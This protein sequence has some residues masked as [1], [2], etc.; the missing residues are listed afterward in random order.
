LADVAGQT[1]FQS[2]VVSSNGR[3]MPGAGALPVVEG[4]SVVGAIAVAGGTEEQDQR[5]AEV[6]LASYRLGVNIGSDRLAAW[7]KG[8]LH[9]RDAWDR[10]SGPAL[11]GS[12]R[13]YRRAGR[14]CRHEPDAAPQE[15]P[16]GA[17]QGALQLVSQ[18]DLERPA[19]ARVGA[20]SLCRPAE[21]P[22][23]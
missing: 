6:A 18:H 8:I 21:F 12:L 16:R 13:S 5:W 22:G 11:P 3:I 4:G 14:Q 2:L 7:G 17:G 20:Q 23:R 10:D 15:L 9:G 19:H 1:W